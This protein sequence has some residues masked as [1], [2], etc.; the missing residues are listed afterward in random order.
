MRSQKELYRGDDF[1]SEEVAPDIWIKALDRLEPTRD[2]IVTPCNAEP[3]IYEGCAEITNRGLARFRTHMYSNCSTLSMEEIRKMDK[4]DNLAF[5]IS[6]HHG[7]IDLMEFIENAKWLQENYNVINFH[8]PMYPPFAEKIL[9]EAKVMK[10][11]GV[12]LDTTHEYLGM[13]K[14]EMHY[15]YL[16]GGDWIKK[17][18]ATA[19]EGTPT[20]KVLCKTSFDHD[21]FFSRT[22]TVAPNGDMY[23]CW[24][25]LYN[26]N[27]D[28]VIGNFFDENFQ[29]EDKHY[30]CDD[31]GDCNI[32]AWHK[33]IKDAETGEQLDSDVNENAGTTIS[34]CMIVRDEADL[35]GD[36]I[37]SILDMVDEII[38][39]DTGSKDDT[40]AIAQK[41]GGD[42][43]KV[44]HYEWNDDFSAARNYSISLATKDWIF[45]IDADERVVPDN[46]KI[47]TNMIGTVKQDII[48][49][50]VNNLY[51]NKET[52]I[53]TPKT[54]LPS[55]RFFK[56]SYHPQYIRAV[57]NQPIVRSGTVVFRLPFTINHLGYD[58]SPER[59][60][61]KYG[62]ILGM[63]KALTLNE[64]D[65]P[66]S[67][68][69]YVRALKV[70]DGKFNVDQLDEMY[71]SLDKGISLGGG[72]FDGQNIH[73]Q[74]LCLAGWIHHYAQDHIKAVE[75]A[76]KALAIKPDYLDAIYLIGM[77]NTYGIDANEGEKWMKRYLDEQSSYDTTSKLDSITMEHYNSRSSAYV[78]LSE[79]EKLREGIK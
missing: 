72:P 66:E 46:G 42:K 15:S 5:Y 30:E 2:L 7:Q 13:Y 3:P 74:L 65:D 44:H 31:Y 21:S 62:R 34:A 14:G 29:F 48:A 24:R 39:V 56:R 73:L 38:L 45:I 6:Y 35:I 58:L 75:Y 51:M 69:H 10:E 41:A 50:Q 76:K 49:V 53:R 55:L 32:C 59:M 26:K 68:F 19:L 16:G 1:A 40:I 61:Q 60:A 54:T 25:H 23:T 8:A 12:I 36:A 20:R 71:E 43:V 77:A 18:L 11:H 17:R 78:A 9:E 4:R 22:Y 52:G 67:W 28:Y 33:D 47:L 63:C 64:P 70:K 79:I 57:H 27:E 37:L